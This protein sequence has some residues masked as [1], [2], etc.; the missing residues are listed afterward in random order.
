MDKLVCIC[1][2]EGGISPS[3][4]FTFCCLSVNAQ[5]RDELEDV[6][7]LANE[8]PVCSRDIV[9][10]YGATLREAMLAA[11]NAYVNSRYRTSK[12]R[13]LLPCERAQWSRLFPDRESVDLAVNVGYNSS[14]VDDVVDYGDFGR[15]LR[16]AV[17]VNNKFYYRAYALD[18]V[19]DPELARRLA[20]CSVVSVEDIPIFGHYDCPA[21][22]LANA[23]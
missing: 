5:Q 16:A 10:V 8:I 12:F 21:I 6:I 14:F 7:A 20:A 9:C 18:K 2:F 17:R 23:L 1:M 13:D 3:G 22:S 19:R 11:D 4:T 15:Y